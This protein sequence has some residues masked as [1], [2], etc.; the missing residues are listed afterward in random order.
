MLF[1]GEFLLSF[2]CP[3]QEVIVR[4]LHIALGELGPDKPGSCN[5]A[6]EFWWT[7]EGAG[8]DLCTSVLGA[9]IHSA[10]HAFA[11]QL[12]ALRILNTWLATE[13]WAQ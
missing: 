9:L 10:E 3:Q 7:P 8:L 12:N 11:F 2:P 4:Y 6:A 5:V 1:H 13:T